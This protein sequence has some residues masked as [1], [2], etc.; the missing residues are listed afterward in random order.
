MARTSAAESKAKVKYIEIK[1][2]GKKE[3]GRGKE[4]CLDHPMW[5][6]KSSFPSSF[7]LRRKWT[8][9]RKRREKNP[10]EKEEKTSSHLT[11]KPT[12]ITHTSAPT[13]EKVNNKKVEGSSHKN[14]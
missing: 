4:A 13:T 14:Q 6:M 1:G 7:H 11:G 12:H 2:M 3:E 8:K 9:R 10:K 5:Q